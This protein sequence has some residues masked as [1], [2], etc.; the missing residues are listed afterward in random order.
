[1]LRCWPCVQPVKLAELLLLLLLLL[2]V[3]LL[4]QV[5]FQHDLRMSDHPGLLAAV[6]SGAQHV[7]PFFCLDPQLYAPLC[8]IP[9]GPASEQLS[10]ASVCI[11]SSSTVG[12]L[13]QSLIMRG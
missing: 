5:W 2:L 4:L 8:L 1:M 6:N 11:P 7:V 9:A 12:L 10:Q 13:R 3:L